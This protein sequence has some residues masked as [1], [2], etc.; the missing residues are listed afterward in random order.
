MSA[1][2]FYESTALG[3]SV[4]RLRQHGVNLRLHI[5]CDNAQPLAIAYNQAISTAFAES[6]VIFAHDDID[7]HDWHLAHRLDQALQSFDVVGVAG[8]QHDQPE[9]PGWAFPKQKGTW[10]P[11]TNL[12]GCIG[13]DTRHRTGPGRKIKILS[14]YG[15]PTGSAALL[16]GVF[17]AVRM[18][19]LLATGLR[20]DP[21]FAFHFYDLDFCRSARSLG[22]KLGVWPI[23]LTHLS[24][25][26]FDDATWSRTCQ[27]YHDKWRDKTPTSPHTSS[28]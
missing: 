24:G 25:G 18:R 28:P 15:Q 16:D 19:Q 23:A 20:F 1:K 21:A 3:R 5:R 22:L 11:A 7:L 13:H 8:S 10:A 27:R 14:R 6:I 17:L 26:N 4:Q 12:L 9:Q 2:H